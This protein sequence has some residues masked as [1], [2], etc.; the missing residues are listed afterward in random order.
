MF[1]NAVE[2]MA[3]SQ[4]GG[5]FAEILYAQDFTADDGTTDLGDGSSIFSTDGSSQVVNG[6]LRMTEVN[7]GD[8]KSVFLTPQFGGKTGNIKTGEPDPSFIISI[9]RTLLLAF[10][11]VDVHLVLPS[12]AGPI[13]SFQVSP[14]ISP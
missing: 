10:G 4:G 5:G 2:Y 1:L 3:P 8:V 13:T 7:V 9:F 11:L 6:G 12:A 14:Q